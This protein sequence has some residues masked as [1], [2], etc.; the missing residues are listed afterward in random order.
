M[1]FEIA[2]AMDS[3][4]AAAGRAEADPTRPVYHFR[5]PAQWMNDPN[6]T[7]FHN[8]WYHVFYQHNP[9]GDAWGHMHWGHARSRDL[10]HWEHM[11][12]ALWPSR[13]E[14]EAHC[15]SGCTAIDGGGRPVIFYTSIP[16]AEGPRQGAE[17][18]AAVGDDELVVWE[19]HA[20]NPILSGEMHGGM[21]VLEWRD[22]FVFREGSRTFMVLGGKLEERDGGEAVVLVYEA[23]DEG[24]ERWRYGGVLFRH[25]DKGLRSIECP[26]FA[27][28]GDRYVLMFS[29]YGPVEWYVGEFDAD[30]VSFR[31]EERGRVDASGNYYAT[32]VLYDGEGRCVLFGW[33]KGFEGGRGWNGCAGLPRVLSLRR[34]GRLGQEPAPEVEK[35]RGG[36]V[37][38]PETELGNGEWVMDGVGGDTLEIAVEIEP[39]DARAFGLRVR[40]SADGARGVAIRWEAGSLDVAGV[41]VPLELDGHDKTLRLRVFVDRSVVEVFANGR[42]CVTRVVYPEPQDLGVEVFAEDGGVVVKSVEVWEVVPIW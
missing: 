24:L 28:V 19:K 40:R 5:P 34:D 37:R 21:E 31:V 42:E 10:V 36:S 13:E 22:P 16:T 23:E 20:G 25:A 38:F 7:I 15:F 39:Q 4:R 6:G 9:Y 26:N 14:G 30:A 2:K 33:V 32:N 8:G 1:R 17:Q 11:P 18:W 27:K 12:M 35:L 41:K 3:V 29:P